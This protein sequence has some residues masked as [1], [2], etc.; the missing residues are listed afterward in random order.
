M[1]NAIWSYGP[2]NWGKELLD[3]TIGK[4]DMQRFHV[5]HVA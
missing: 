5:K 3:M 2:R 1:A 4:Y